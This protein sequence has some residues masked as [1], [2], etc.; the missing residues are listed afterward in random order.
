M[1]GILELAKP[2]LELSFLATDLRTNEISFMPSNVSLS[3]WRVDKSV[4]IL[5]VL[6]T[7]L[8]YAVPGRNRHNP[9]KYICRILLK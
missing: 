6:N 1:P 3:P 8:A 5:N 2:T 7:V 4:K 9:W